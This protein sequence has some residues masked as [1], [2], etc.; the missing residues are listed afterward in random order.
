MR[1][2]L[3]RRVGRRRIRGELC[4]RTG[5]ARRRGEIVK[6]S[7]EVAVGGRDV[8]LS[9]GHVTRKRSEVLRCDAVTDPNRDDAISNLFEI[10]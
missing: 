10:V 5:R 2:D 9:S 1:G 8:L 4:W 7:A 3:R 6:H